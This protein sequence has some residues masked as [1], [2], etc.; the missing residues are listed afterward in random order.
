MSQ[1]IESGVPLSRSSLWKFQE[2]YY[3]RRGPAAFSSGEVPWRVSSTPLAGRLMAEL[4][5]AYGQDT[6]R[7]VEVLELGGGSARFAFHV[8]RA[9]EELGLP[10]LYRFTDVSDSNLMAAS[11]HPRLKPF[12]ADGRLVV[13]RRDALT[14]GRVAGGG[15]TAVCVVG[16]YLFDTLPHDV[17]EARDGEVREGRV[18]LEGPSLSEASWSFEYAAAPLPPVVERFGRAMG[19]A[20]FPWPTGAMACIESLGEGPYVLVFSDKVITSRDRLRAMEP[21]PLARHGSVSMTVNIPAIRAWWGWRPFF[22]PDP[23]TDTFGVF[24]LTRGFRRGEL[25]LFDAQ[26][27]ATFARSPALRLL[28]LVDEAVH[29][30][31]LPVPR[32]LELLAVSRF[33]PDVF[34]RLASPLSEEI[35][36][37]VE[38]R[39]V[40]PLVEALS[41]VSEMHFELKE[42]YDVQLEVAR[43]LH[44]LGQLSAAVEVY[45]RSIDERGESADAL[46]A[47]AAARADLGAPAVARELLQ[48]AIRVDPG[49]E[50]ARRLLAK[51]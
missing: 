28:A 29:T 25:R 43:L 17:F 22:Q 7:P 2:E 46:V 41:R 21:V 24:A 38:D 6:G 39:W 3:Q 31:P 48:R 10:L 50:P 34:L 15:D 1:R 26:Y 49:H 5:E 42:P 47:M 30:R 4:L 11:V 45:Q 44:R 32:A 33:D 19:Q 14:P 8:L 51:L 13:E 37:G 20:R 16:N 27:Q 40:A 9:A 18:T 36:K 23:A 12:L 35:A